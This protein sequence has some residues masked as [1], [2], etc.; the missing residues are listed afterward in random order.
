M[1]TEWMGKYRQ[2]VAALVR[3]GNVMSQLQWKNISHDADILPMTVNEWQV[4][5][6]LLEHPESDSNMAKIADALGDAPS[7]FSKIVSSLVKQ[8]FVQK[9]MR[10]GNRKDIILR[11]SNKGREYYDTASQRN[12]I[13]V[14][15][16]L[17]VALEPLNED[18]LAIVAKGISTLDRA[19]ISFH[20]EPKSNDSDKLTLIS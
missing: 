8:G 10:V 18:Q 17:F 13:P 2:V 11:I 16:N 19:M 20:S 15:T 5:E 3:H 7:T 14:F 9:Y 1:G 6:Y 4:L 12:V